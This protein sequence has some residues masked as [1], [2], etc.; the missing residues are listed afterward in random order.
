MISL[1]PLTLENRR[2]VFNLSV[3]KDQEQ[4]VASNLSSVA[5]AY[6]LMT[7]GGLQCLLLSIKT[8]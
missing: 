3:S 8:K 5:T 6:I 7:N 1:R 4:F 2:T